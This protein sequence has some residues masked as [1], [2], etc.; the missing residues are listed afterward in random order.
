MKKIINTPEQYTDD[1]LRG[2]YAA[3]SEKVRYVNHDLR[4]YCTKNKTQ[5]KVAIITGGGTGPAAL[6]WICRRRPFRWL[7]SGECISITFCRTNLSYYQGSG[8]RCRSFIHL[9]ELY[10]R[11]HEL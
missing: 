2:I 7:C 9:W 5:G 8:K 1:M 11:H 6:P 10:R 3:H 4:C